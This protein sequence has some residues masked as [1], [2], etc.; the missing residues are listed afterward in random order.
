ME[1]PQSSFSNDGTPWIHRRMCA[2]CHRRLNRRV[3]GDG[4][5]TIYQHGWGGSDHEPVPV[6][7]PEEQDVILVCDFC[8]DPHPT[9]DFGCENFVDSGTVT[10]N[11]EN[12]IGVA[13]GDW[14]AC[15]K[16]KD[17]IVADQYERLAD[18]SIQGQI[19]HNPDAAAAYAASPAIMFVNRMGMMNLHQQFRK[20]RTGPPTPITQATW[21]ASR[22]REVIG[23]QE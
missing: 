1:E 8:L 16:C 9:W 11:P 14:A 19:T 7:E 2:V 22:L 13:L 20:A 5:T 4:K 12:D 21:V 6:M 3:S 23:E 10:P 15:D 18:R 17:L